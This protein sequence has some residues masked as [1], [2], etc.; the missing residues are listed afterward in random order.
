M[1]RNIPIVAISL[2]A[3]LLSACASTGSQGEKLVSADGTVPFIVIGKT[4]QTDVEANM[5]AAKVMRFKT[6]YQVWVYNYKV[7]L[8]RIADY[9][10]VVGGVAGLYKKTQDKKELAILFDPSGVVK[11]YTLREEPSE[12]ADSRTHN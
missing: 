6:G 8:P 10:P 12:R 1:K 11:K 7:E 9:V 5:G 3:I 2:L 4:T